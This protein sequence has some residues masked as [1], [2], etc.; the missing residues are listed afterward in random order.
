MTS[1]SEPPFYPALKK[2]SVGVLGGLKVVGHLFNWAL[3]LHTVS[4]RSQEEE[5]SKPEFR[6]QPADT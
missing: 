2:V 5:G 6:P 3:M 1:F 4:L